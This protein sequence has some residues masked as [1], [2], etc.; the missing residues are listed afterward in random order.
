MISRDG[1][2]AICARIE[3]DHPVG[4]QGAGWLH[5]IN[6]DTTIVIPPA[7][8]INIQQLKKAPPDRLN[9]VYLALLNELP[10]SENHH[11]N[12]LSRGLS[13]AEI[14]NLKYRTLPIDGY[15]TIAYRLSKT[16][17]LAGVPGFYL[18]NGNVKLAGVAGIFI[19]VRDTRGRI[20]GCQIRCDHAEG[21]KYRWLSSAN[22]PWGCSSGAPA[23]VARADD[24]SEIWITE[25]P[26]KA[27]IA[28]IKLSRTVLAVAG[29]GN[30]PGVIPILSDLRPARVVVAFDRDNITNQA[31]KLHTDNLISYL[32]NCGICTYEATWNPDYKGIDDLLNKKEI[33]WLNP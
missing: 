30:W 23:H 22:Y 32:I 31:V 27:D 5:R 24:I 18:D 11:N 10:L 3:S 6:G 9:T 17:R 19:P 14:Q 26:I 8:K 29:V 13:D 7:P 1:K 15:N 33:R 21:G 25:G 12:L 28:A 20:A 4:N 16:H 2:S